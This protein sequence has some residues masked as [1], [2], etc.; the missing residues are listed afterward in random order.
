MPLFVVQVI[1]GSVVDLFLS[2]NVGFVPFP[3]FLTD[4]LGAT[5][6]QVFLISL[7]KSTTDALF[8]V[9]MGRIVRRR[10]GIGLQAQAAGRCA[11]AFSD[12]IR[13]YKL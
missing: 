6:A 10:R 5:N 4:A 13:G 8:Y 3:I 2:I 7:V 12:A 11:S 1:G 9:P